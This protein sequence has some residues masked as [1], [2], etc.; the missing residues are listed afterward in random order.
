MKRRLSSLEFLLVIICLLLLVCCV[1]LIVVTWI[2]FQPEAGVEPAPLS[3]RMV[4]T[5][6][7]AFC[8]ELKN[9]SSLQ[10]KSLA[11]DV[12]HLVRL[13]LL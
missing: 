8:E 3:G 2:S 13:Q 9:S 11:F 4:I 12:Q 6:G 10:F 1:G 7:A 5:E